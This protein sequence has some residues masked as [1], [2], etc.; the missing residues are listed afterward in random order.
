V[1]TVPRYDQILAGF[2]EGDAISHAAVVM[3]DTF[4]RWGAAS[5]IY[6][7]F[8]HASPSVRDDCRPL[9]TYRGATGDVVCHHFSIGSP[10]IDVFAASPA[11]K[12]IVYH[13]ITPAEYYDGFDDT[14]AA[15]L[16]EARRALGTLAGRVDA[17]WAVS[18]FNAADLE[19][20]GFRS[21]AVFPLIFDA[22]RLDVP[23]DPDVTG[24]FT[25][26]LTTF[27]CVGRI[28][29]NKGLETLIEAFYWYWKTINPYSRL[30][31]VGSD[32]SCPKYF[33]MLRMLVGDLDIANVCF[34][35]FASPAGLPAYYKLADCFIT[36][37][38][39]EGYCLPLLEA[40]H[41]GVPVIARAIG[42]MPEATDGAG[43]LYDDMKPSELAG[44]MDRVARDPSWR[45]EI[46][47]SQA[48]RLEA[49]RRRDVDGELRALLKT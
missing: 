45:A 14:V 27:L 37:S 6:V 15:Q 12:V 34:E 20:L 5:D 7:P 3:R 10:A 33:A 30:V 4:R 38:E 9:D 36:S 39:H 25:A 8:E 42:G 47:A 28:A 21:V 44:L 18:S 11:R 1:S 40:M 31:I 17:A 24:K 26:K 48:R 19:Q 35:G 49:L 22:A 23:P 13:N 41:M 32:R 43:V 29:P 16:R 46:L 2:A